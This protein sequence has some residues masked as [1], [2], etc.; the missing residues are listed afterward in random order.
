MPAPATVQEFLALVQQ[1][2]VAEGKRLDLYLEQAGDLPK[3]PTEFA[4]VFVR[5]GLL[6]D[7]QAKSLLQGK[8]RGYTLGKYKILERIGSGGMNSVF[9]CVHPLM[10]R[11]VAVKVLSN[12]QAMNETLLKRFYREA[13]A[14]AALDHPNIVHAYDI[15]QV[16][17]G[18]LLV[19]EYIDGTDLRALVLQHGPLSPLRASHYLRQAALGLQ[20][21]QDAGLVHRDMKPSNLL[22]DRAGTIKIL[23]LGLARFSN[24]EE[25]ILTQGVLG[26][27]DYLAPEQ[28]IDSHAVDIRADIY[29]LGGT[30]YFALTGQLPFGEGTV[31]QKVIAHRTQEPKPLLQLRPEVPEGLAAIITRM[32]SKDP[33]KRYQTPREVV[34][35][36]IPWTRGPCPLPSEAEM[37]RL[38]LAA[39]GGEPLPPPRVAPPSPAAPPSPPQPSSPPI[40]ARPSPSRAPLAAVSSSRAVLKTAG[41]SSAKVPVS[42]APAAAA[43]SLSKTTD[44]SKPGKRRDANTPVASTVATQPATAVAAPIRTAPSKPRPIVLQESRGGTWLWWLVAGAGAVGVAAGGIIAWALS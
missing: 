27:A 24:D 18:H 36:M 17:K 40:E 12:S 26:T 32:M 23:D 20:H 44:R 28:T 37:P 3:E 41:R 38:S 15:D 5:D 11:R 42:P 22:L 33:A 29:S 31:A 43:A 13:R 19:M 4:N 6:T 8:S 21:A 35:A 9:L 25:D 14:A 1:S 34:E 39:L 16:D 10:N 2:G 7:F 30:F